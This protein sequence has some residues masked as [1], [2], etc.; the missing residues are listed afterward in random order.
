MS[1]LD[2]PPNAPTPPKT[3][4]STSP[5]TLNDTSTNTLPFHLAGAFAPVREERTDVDLDVVGE[6][7]ADLRGTYVR[8]GPNPRTGWSPAWFAAEGMLHGVRLEGGRARWYRN[9]W[10]KGIYANTNVIRHAG[11]HLRIW[12]P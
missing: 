7:P 4:P 1:N 10:I 5:S 6:I 8:N 9:R 3:P 11:R 12:P 2:M